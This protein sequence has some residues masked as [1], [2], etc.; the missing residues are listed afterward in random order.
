[1]APE[2]LAGADAEHAKIQLRLSLG[3][4]EAVGEHG[5][6][7]LADL[8]QEPGERQTAG[9]K[10][11]SPPGAHYPRVHPAHGADGTRGIQFALLDGDGQLAL[12]DLRVVGNGGQ[13]LLKA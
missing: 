3:V 7:Q 4:L 5:V 9:D 12:G 11:W 2:Q 10:R 1:L 6:N 8:Q 13:P